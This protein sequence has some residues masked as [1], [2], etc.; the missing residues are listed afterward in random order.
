MDKIFKRGFHG[1][2]SLGTVTLNKIK[3]NFFTQ[4]FSLQIASLVILQKGDRVCI[5]SLI[6]FPPENFLLQIISQNQSK[7]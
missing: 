5:V 2:I 7:Y 3:H 4:S 6:I 1:Q